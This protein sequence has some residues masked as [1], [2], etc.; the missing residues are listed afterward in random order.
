MPQ[1]VDYS[2]LAFGSDPGSID[3]F[4]VVLHRPVRQILP[5]V[6][7]TQWRLP[8]LSLQLIIHWSSYYSRH[9]V[10]RTERIVKYPSNNNINRTLSSSP[11][12]ST[13]QV[14]AQSPVRK[15][16]MCSLHIGLPAPASSCP[17]G[18]CCS[19]CFCIPFAFSSASILRLYWYLEAMLLHCFVRLCKC[20][21]DNYA[22]YNKIYSISIIA[23][24]T[25]YNH[26]H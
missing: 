10:L 2:S 20:R 18:L 16:S 13:V 4:L 15:P 26:V 25:M 23:V 12:L 21:K 9:Y 22:V 14:Q 11:P 8:S 3:R 1:S 17:S 6:Y 24:T 19:V 5:Y 7:I